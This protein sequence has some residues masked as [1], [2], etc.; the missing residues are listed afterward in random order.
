[1]NLGQFE[2]ELWIPRSHPAAHRGTISLGEMASGAA[3]LHRN[4]RRICP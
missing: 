2:P 4:D 3:K 1:M